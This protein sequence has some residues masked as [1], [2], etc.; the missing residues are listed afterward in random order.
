MTFIRA[1]ATAKPRRSCSDKLPHLFP[2]G[3][4][5]LL[6]AMP[7]LAG[8]STVGGS[9][10]GSVAGRSAAN[11]APVLGISPRPSTVSSARS[12]SV[13]WPSPAKSQDDDCS[14]S[15]LDGR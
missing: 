10:P 13:R 9:R 2:Q 8:G 6:E 4:A 12:G 14:G 5:Q 11:G 1:I 7:W 3:T 15:S